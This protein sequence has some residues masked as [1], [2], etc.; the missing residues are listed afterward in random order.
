MADS[1]PSPPSSSPD[2]AFPSERQAPSASSP[3]HP[4]SPAT[5]RIPA[6]SASIPPA[7]AGAFG[8][9][10]LALLSTLPYLLLAPLVPSNR[11]YAWSSTFYFDD[12][13]QYFAWARRIAAGDWFLRNHYTENPAASFALLNPWFLLLGG[14]TRATGD[15]ILAS[16]LLRAVVV[17]LFAPVAWR[18]LGGFLPARRARLLAFGLL[19]AGGLEYPRYL[20]GEALGLA[21]R[22]A[23]PLADPY[24]YKILYRYGHLTAALILLL[25][26]FDLMARAGERDRSEARGRE[27]IRRGV[28]IATLLAL[29]GAINPYYLCL[30]GAVCGLVALLRAAL[31]AEPDRARDLVAL[32]IGG[33][34]PAAHYA[35]QPVTSALGSIAFDDPIG[36]GDL[37]LFHGVLL[38]WAVAGRLRW[39]RDPASAPPPAA[40]ILWDAWAAFVVASTLT[41]LA[42]RAR[43]TFGSSFLLAIPAAGAMLAPRDGPAGAWTAG[44]SPVARRALVAVT[45]LACCLDAAFTFYKETIDL[46]R[47]NVGTIERP[48]LLAFEALQERVRP[49]D[50]VLTTLAEGNMLPAFVD[51]NVYAG[52]SFQTEDYDRKADAIESFLVRMTPDERAR[53]LERIG[54]DFVLLPPLVGRALPGFAVAG[55]DAFYERSGYRILSPGSA[56]RDRARA[57][58]P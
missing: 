18:F 46:R 21:T 45:L 26:L 19:F 58:F 51:A 32:G 53:F 42:F 27:G 33:A 40:R 44:R 6:S 57:V 12:Q 11:I 28:A 13:F 23:T 41:P 24:A 2:P 8:A 36:P 37:L 7:L 54:A 48:L 38:P 52:H 20:A 29:L 43:L 34:I 30:A 50:V 39:R 3:A 49:G 22:P 16:Q 4:A 55:W 31:L 10:L 5:S 17:A 56:V 25:L 9:V 47:R 35:L 15:P 1:A 14:A